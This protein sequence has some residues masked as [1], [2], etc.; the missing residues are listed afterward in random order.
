MRLLAR[1]PERSKSLSLPV[2]PQVGV[3][4][5]PIEKAPSGTARKLSLCPG[6]SFLYFS[7]IPYVCSAAPASPRACW[8][9]PSASHLFKTCYHVNAYGFFGHRRKRVPLL[10]ISGEL[11]PEGMT[12]IFHIQK[13]LRQ[14]NFHAFGGIGIVCCQVSRK[15]STASPSTIGLASLPDVGIIITCSFVTGASDEMFALR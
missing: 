4:Q 5:A 13:I 10:I 12:H 7:S 2:T 8:D 15:E 3:R 1:Y 11:Q 14:T 6:T 9:A